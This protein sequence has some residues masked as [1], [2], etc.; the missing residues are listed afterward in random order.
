MAAP[1]ESMRVKLSFVN[2]ASKPTLPRKLWMLVDLSKTKTVLDLQCA[3]QSRFNLSCRFQ[4]F[5][6]GCLIPSWEDVIIIRD[7]EELW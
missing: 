4:L 7:N 1:T 2:I 5:V 6:D 3:I